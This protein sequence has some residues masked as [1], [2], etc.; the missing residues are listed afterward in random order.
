MNKPAVHPKGHPAKPP[1]GFFPLPS[2]DR[3]TLILCGIE[4]LI[5]FINNQMP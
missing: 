1:D 4:P 2:V 3:H 5:K